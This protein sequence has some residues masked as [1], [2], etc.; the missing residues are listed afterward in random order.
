MSVRVLLVGPRGHGGEGVYMSALRQHPPEGVAYAVAGDFHE[1][2][3]GAPC[4][5]VQEMALN[6]IVH[7]LAVP[8]MGFRALRLRERFDLVHV[9]VHPVRL[10]GRN[11]PPLVMSEGSSAAVYIGDYLGWDERR[12]AR[13]LRRSRRLYR[14]LGIADR[15]MTLDRATVA[16]VF[17][18]WAH[19]VNVRWGADPEKL[20]IVSPGFPDPG[21][22]V[23]Q[24]RGAFTFLF[25]GGDFERK[26]RL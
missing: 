11:S 19:E 9:H 16:Y 15:L 7:R 6:Q 26:G 24:K 8:D 3:P 20:R 18:Q 5:L 23:R 4:R 1:G 17:S 22:C 12:L 14:L 13:G 10:S 25:V 2:A 21:P